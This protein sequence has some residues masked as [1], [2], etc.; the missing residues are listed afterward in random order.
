LATID[1]ASRLHNFLSDYRKE[2]EE[3]SAHGKIFEMEELNV[4]LNDFLI[5]VGM[6]VLCSSGRCV[7][8]Q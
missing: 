8:L 1:S 6:H 5:G 2:F 3:I 4:A 7:C